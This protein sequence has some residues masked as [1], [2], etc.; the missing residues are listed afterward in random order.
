VVSPPS[1]AANREHHKVKE[2]FRAVILRLPEHLI[3]RIDSAVQDLRCRSRS[4]FLRSAL[5]S[6]VAHYER[7]IRERKTGTGFG[8][9]S[10][11]ERQHNGHIRGRLQDALNLAPE[12]LSFERLE[13]IEKKQMERVEKET[14]SIPDNFV[15]TQPYLERHVAAA[16]QTLNLEVARLVAVEATQ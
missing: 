1:P 14:R 3:D 9:R 15:A 16:V 8:I 4:Q 2:T 7:Q 12:V 10:E 5:Q 11:N 13:E 6:Q